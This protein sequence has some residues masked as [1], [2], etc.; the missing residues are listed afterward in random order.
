MTVC[1]IKHGPLLSWLVSGP[2][3]DGWV[4]VLLSPKPA[5]F[6]FLIMISI[7]VASRWGNGGTWLHVNFDIFGFRG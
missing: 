1:I 2:N 6:G 3:G 5:F 7:D 4:T